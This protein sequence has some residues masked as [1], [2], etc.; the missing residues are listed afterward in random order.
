MKI[1]R[2]P[3]RAPRANSIAE[4]F[5]GTARRECLDDILI[6]G[7]WHLERVLTDFIEHYHRARPHQGL[8]QQ[9]SRPPAEVRP[10]SGSELLRDDRL[11]GLIHEYR[12]AA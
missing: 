1:V 10:V 8:K 4:R 5:V 3:Y 11:G 7:R 9:L 6:F 12:W 2:L